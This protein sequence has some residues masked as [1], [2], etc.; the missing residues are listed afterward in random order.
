MGKKLKHLE[1]IPVPTQLFPL[2]IPY[3]DLGLNLGLSSKRDGSGPIFVVSLFTFNEVSVSA[4]KW[5]VH[6]DKRF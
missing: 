3:N 1:K 5:M 6:R 4:C 2:L